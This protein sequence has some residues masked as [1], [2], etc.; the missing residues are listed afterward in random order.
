MRAERAPEPSVR[1]GRG[2]SGA[3]GLVLGSF[4]QLLSQ[5]LL[6]AQGRD[7]RAEG[8]S[9]VWWVLAHLAAL[10]GVVSFIVGAFALSRSRPSPLSV[11]GRGAVLLGASAAAGTLIYD[12]A[13]GTVAWTGARIATPQGAARYVLQMLDTLD[14]ALV[15]GLVLVVAAWG[16][17]VRSRLV[18]SWVAMIGLSVPALPGIETIAA[19]AVFVG[20]VVFAAHWLR[21]EPRLLVVRLTAATT[22]VCFTAAAFIS[23][24]RAMLACIAVPI[25]VWMTRR[26]SHREP[27]V[28]TAHGR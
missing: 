27:L 23:L 5:G 14:F 13:L 18:K 12:I 26:G 24:P 9:E 8:S 17:R 6:D 28:P 10:I 1:S 21:W 4:F 3:G 25:V 15:V 11:V 19:A 2:V 20:F 7:L 22:L 16:V